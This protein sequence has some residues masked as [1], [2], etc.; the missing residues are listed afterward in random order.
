ML[1]Y[2]A[3]YYLRSSMECTPFESLPHIGFWL[4]MD[5]TPGI[6]NII[7]D[8]AR[9]LENPAAQILLDNFCILYKVYS[10][11]IKNAGK[12]NIS[13][14]DNLCVFCI[15]SKFTFHPPPPPNKN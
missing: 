13:S 9:G 5:L 6:F 14:S 2:K 7:L 1:Y 15:N 11:L 12:Q 4:G 10:I 8:G 3:C